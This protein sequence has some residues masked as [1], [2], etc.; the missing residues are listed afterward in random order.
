MNR[1]FVALL[2]LEIAAVA[3]GCGGIR[4]CKEGTLFIIITLAGNATTADTLSVRVDIAGSPGTPVDLPRPSDQAT[5]TIEVGFSD[6]YPRGETVNVTITAKKAGQDLAYVTDTAMLGPGCSTMALTVGRLGGADAADAGRGDIYIIDF[7]VP[8]LRAADAS[9]LDASQPGGP[10]LTTPTVSFRPVVTWSTAAMAYSVAATDLDGDARIDVIA[11]SEGV[12]VFIGKGDGSF[13]PRAN[14]PSDGIVAGLT[15][16]DFDNNGCQDLVGGKGGGNIVVLLGNCNGALQAPTSFVAVSP[17]SIINLISG[18]FNS[19]GKLDLA[20][21]HQ[22]SVGVLLGRGNGTFDPAV[23]YTAG[24]NVYSIARGDL[25]RDVKID[26]VVANANSGSVA[27]LLGNGNGTF[28]AAKEFSAGATPQGVA[29]GDF[30]ADSAPDVAAANG[31]A[32]TITIFRGNGDGTLQVTTTI[33]AP[34][35]LSIAAGDMNADGWIDLAF[36]NPTLS[37]VS[38]LRGNGDGTFKAA[39][40]LSV[41]SSPHSITIVDL[42]KDGRDD[43]VTAGD[44]VS[45][46]LAQ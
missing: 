41:G 31:G 7:S 10:D 13:R 33:P 32:K 39:G 23:L 18:D 4:P 29:V 6:G 5:G 27:V 9:T 44:G 43:I 46:L 25:N 42:N 17:S 11:A 37:V 14:Y 8:D 3:T 38:V 26:L 34:A 24:K 28:G 45:I 15:A 1:L 40:D 20:T 35:P 22:A 30:D 2:S 12:D 16:G 36:I 21:A 19:D